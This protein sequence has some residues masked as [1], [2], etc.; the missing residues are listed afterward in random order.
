MSFE[1]QNDLER[2][3]ARAATD[4]AHRPQFYKDLV[5]ADIFIIQYGAA[6]PPE[7][8]QTTLTEGTSIQI[9]NIEYKG[10]RYLP[11]FSSLPRLESVLS[12]EASYLGMNALEFMKMTRG[13][14][15]LLNPGSDFGKEFTVE[16][17]ESIIDGSI[18]SADERYT[19]KQPTQVMIGQPKSYPD[20]LVSALSRFFK[21]KKGVKRAWLAHIF[22]PDDGQKPHTLIAIDCSD[23]DQISSEAGVIVRS[24][25]IPD[26][27]V[28]FIAISGNGGIEDYFI[29]DSAPFYERRLF[30]F[31]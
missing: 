13:T 19:V 6:A 9:Q 10:Q 15:L 14:P 18:W 29:N 30:G 31:F 22:N 28:D 12:S 26:P 2:S 3:L 4:P 8:R 11:V 17:I 24:V 5:A 1:P 7:H 27:P 23:F 21:T 16:E 25:Q 20:E